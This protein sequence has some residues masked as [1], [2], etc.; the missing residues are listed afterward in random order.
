VFWT[1]L[2]P[3]EDVMSL[4]Q[5]IHNPLVL[6]YDNIT[7]LVVYFRI[8]Q[9]NILSSL[10]TTHGRWVYEI[11]RDKRL[12]TFPHKAVML[13]PRIQEDW[14]KCWLGHWLPIQRLCLGF[15]SPSKQM[16]EQYLKLGNMTASF[17]ILS[18]SLFIKSFNCL[19]P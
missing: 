15:F 12:Q 4:D 17:H 7:S 6:Q 19:I 13:L 9:I 14:F 2:F 18:N 11:Y 1:F 3:I 8:E 10:I 5:P 16:P